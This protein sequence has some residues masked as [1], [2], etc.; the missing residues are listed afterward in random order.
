MPTM[1]ISGSTKD[2]QA[3]YPEVFRAFYEHLST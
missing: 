2:Q 1:V 3:D